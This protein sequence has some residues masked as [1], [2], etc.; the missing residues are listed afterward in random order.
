MDIIKHVLSGG[1][2]SLFLAD[3]ISN[4]AALLNVPGTT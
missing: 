4:L 1:P 2:P 3:H